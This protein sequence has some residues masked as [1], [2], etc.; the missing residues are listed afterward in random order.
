MDVMSATINGQ[1]GESRA[2]WSRDSVRRFPKGPNM[3]VGHCVWGKT[4]KDP[5][6]LKVHRVFKAP[7]YGLVFLDDPV[8]VTE[9][10]MPQET[11]NALGLS[12]D[13]GN[14]IDEIRI[15]P[16]LHSVML[17]TKPLPVSQGSK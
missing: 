7:G 17:G 4:D 1:E 16:T 12:V 13:G 3:I 15:G 9:G 6:I 11:I 5:D 10:T 8:N 14:P 2:G